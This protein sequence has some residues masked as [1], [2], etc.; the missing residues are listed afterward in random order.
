M[1][2]FLW[3][4]FYRPWAVNLTLHSVADC[5]SLLCEELED[6]ETK[7]SQRCNKRRRK[8]G[9]VQQQILQQRDDEEA[10]QEVAQE[11]EQE[12]R[13]IKDESKVLTAESEGRA[14]RLDAR[15]EVE[16]VRADDRAESNQETE[17]REEEKERKSSEKRDGRKMSR[18]RKGRKQIERGRNQK[19][20]KRLSG[21]QE[22]NSRSQT[23]EVSAVSSEDSS[24]PLVPLMDS[25][26]LPD[27][28]HTGCGLAGLCC[29]PVATLSSSQPPASTQP[30]P[31]QPHGTTRPL[32]PLLAH[33]LPQPGPQPLEVG[34]VCS[35][36]LA[37]PEM[38]STQGLFIS[39]T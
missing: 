24:E 8:E 25:C 39:F 3:T 11:K 36:T 22:E 35:L 6:E 10:A 18:K 26:D 38:H 15:Q 34:T 20:V 13:G 21:Q 1:F 9:E 19:H 29:P 32:S 33:S 23:Q 30:G 28:V 31:A 37:E 17:T 16:D 12:V 7:N 4:V 27:P 14:V 5:P 2:L